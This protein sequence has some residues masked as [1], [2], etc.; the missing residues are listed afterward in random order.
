MKYR[1]DEFIIMQKTDVLSQNLRISK[2]LYLPRKGLSKQSSGNWEYII[3]EVIRKYSTD[4]FGINGATNLPEEL[5][6][7]FFKGPDVQ[8]MHQPS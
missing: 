4:F 8:N 1:I 7:K 5:W 6:I 3:S 2:Y